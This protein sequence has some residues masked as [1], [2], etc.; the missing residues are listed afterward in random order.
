MKEY[1]RLSRYRQ[2][3]IMDCFCADLAA[4]QAAK[5]L[6]LNRK[7]I[8]RYSGNFRAAIATKQEADKA[9]FAGIVELDES[10]FGADHLRGHNAQRSLF[11]AFF[12]KKFGVVIF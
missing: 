7:T 5:I 10:Y 2:E 11:Y 12:R 9:A 3:K 6:G 4:T 8:N 1:S